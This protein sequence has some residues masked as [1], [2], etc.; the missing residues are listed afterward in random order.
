MSEDTEQPG[1]EPAAGTPEDAAPPAEAVSAEGIPA[2]PDEPVPQAPVS[3]GGLRR[4]PS[5]ARV[6]RR[7]AADPTR[8]PSAR[9]ELVL[10]STTA[11]IMGATARRG[12]TPAR[13]R[14]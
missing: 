8:L 2:F 9:C 11:R 6:R 7:R 4:H 1:P 5:R 3:A 10:P 14:R 13:P 12:A